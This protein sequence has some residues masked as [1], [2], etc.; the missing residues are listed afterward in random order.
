MSERPSTT[1]NLANAATGA[2]SALTSVTLHALNGAMHP[3]RTARVIGRLVHRVV[4]EPGTAPGVLIQARPGRGEKVRLQLLEYGPDRFGEEELDDVAGA[5]AARDNPAVSWVNVDG[6]HDLEVLSR[7]R[8]HFSLHPLVME[9]VVQVGHRAKV[10]EYEGYLYL[11]LPMLRFNEE[12]GTVEAEQVSVILGP[13]WVLTFQEEQVGDAFEPVRARLRG[14]HGRIRHRGA[15]YLAYALVDAVVDGYFLILE[16]LGDAVEALDEEVMGDPAPTVLHRIHHLKRELLLLRK[17]VWPLREA[18]SSFARTESELVSDATQLF[19]RDVYD[20]A[21]QV[22][23]TV[24]TLRDLAAGITDL[25]LSRVGQ[26]TNEVMKVL[27]IMATIFIPLTFIV[28]VYGMN[29]EY[30]PEL[31]IPWAYPALWALMIGL[32]GGMTWVFR[33]RKWL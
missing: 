26:R 24:E 13:T 21:I 27:T 3:L 15:D 14:S 1:S 12:Q 2:A 9:D 11:V 25:Y 30:M 4:Q 23:D 17:S 6:L 28:G 19:A 32:G 16:R 31:R 5:L 10:E 20:H 29:F 8:D 18:L 7:L 33:K 22:I